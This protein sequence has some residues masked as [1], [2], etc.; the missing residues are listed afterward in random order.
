[1]HLDVRHFIVARSIR[2]YR[3]RRPP[4]AFS[5]SFQEEKFHTMVTIKFAELH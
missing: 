5:P 2:E 1:V 4:Y 3:C